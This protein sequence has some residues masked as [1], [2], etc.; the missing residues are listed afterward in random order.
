MLSDLLSCFT[1]HLFVCYRASAIIYSFQLT[2]AGSLWNLFR[3]AYGPRDYSFFVHHKILPGKRY[4]ILRNRKDP[5]DYDVD[6][7]LLG[8]MLFTLVAF[9]SPTIFTYYAFFATVRCITSCAYL[10][11]VQPPQA[12]LLVVIVHAI[13]DTVLVLMNHFPLFALLLRTK[14]PFRMPGMLLLN[15]CCC[16]G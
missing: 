9:L 11:D 7:L 4:N 10:T 16:A 15:E 13:L 12:R 8:T 14:S 1:F 3:G 6:Q 2:V 5:W